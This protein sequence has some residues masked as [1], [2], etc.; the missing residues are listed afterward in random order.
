MRVQ[1]QSWAGRVVVRVEV[2]N[3]L[4]SAAVTGIYLPDKR[5]RSARQAGEEARSGESEVGM[6]LMNFK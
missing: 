1:L 3:T 2:G 5:A 6:P 4:L